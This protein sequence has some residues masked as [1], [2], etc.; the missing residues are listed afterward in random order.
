M[1]VAISKPYT[2]SDKAPVDNRIVRRWVFNAPPLIDR[3]EN[4]VGTLTG[5]CHRNHRVQGLAVGRVRM[6][7]R[8]C[9]ANNGVGIFLHES[10]ADHR[11][12]E[13]CSV[14]S[15]CIAVDMAES[16]SHFAGGIGPAG[17]QYAV[18][19][20]AE[21]WTDRPPELV[22]TRMSGVRRRDPMFQQKQSLFTRS[23]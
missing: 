9:F 20:T 17:I 11:R 15:F 18:H 22:V 21:L 5:I 19:I 10:K 1:K 13:D 23:P 2:R 14:R 12:D 7:E 4:F 8:R 16:S 3:P 6:D